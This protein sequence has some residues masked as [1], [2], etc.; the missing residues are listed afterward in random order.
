MERNIYTQYFDTSNSRN[1]F[2]QN[3]EENK[4]VN[5]PPHLVELALCNTSYSYKDISIKAI[6]MHLIIAKL[7]TTWEKSQN[8]N[9][10]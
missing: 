6:D 2:K 1:Y 4:T 3:F 9:L 10:H 5:G 7:A 8:A